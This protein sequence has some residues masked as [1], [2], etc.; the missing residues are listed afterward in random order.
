MYIC[1]IRPALNYGVIIIGPPSPKNPCR[2]LEKKQGVF[3]F[4][5]YPPEERDNAEG[6]LC[7]QFTYAII[8]NFWSSK[9][10]SE[11]PS[12]TP[13]IFHLL[14]QKSF[15]ASNKLQT[16]QII[17]NLYQDFNVHP[18]NMSVGLTEIGPIA[19]FMQNVRG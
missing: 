19:Y 18:G 15:T 3:P 4:G 13:K 17:T 6:A 2:R 5:A 9:C 14:E 16:I 1:Y 8:N 12:L 11:N 7:G 10:N